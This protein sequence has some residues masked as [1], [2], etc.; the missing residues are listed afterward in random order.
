MLGCAWV[1]AASLVSAAAADDVVLEKPKKQRGVF[2]YAISPDGTRIAGGTGEVTRRADGRNKMSGGEVVLWDARSGKL[3]ET[4]GSHDGTVDWVSFAADGE[5]LASCS[6]EDGVVQWWDVPAGKPKGEIELEG[7]HFGEC[8]PVLSPDGRWVVTVSDVPFQVGVRGRHRGGEVSIWKLDDGQE[9]WSIP[10]S[11]AQ[12]AAIDPSNR[13]LAV[14]MRELQW[15][16][17]AN[18]QWAGRPVREE[19]V[20]YDLASGEARHQR[21]LQAMDLCYTADGKSLAALIWTGVLILS[22]EDLSIQRRLEISGDNW[23]LELAAD[24]GSFGLFH[25]RNRVVEV[26]GMADGALLRR[27][28]SGAGRSLARPALSRDLTR[29]VGDFGADPILRDVPEVTG[30]G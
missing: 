18:G 12:T 28:E 7:A 22:T 11:H 24:G 9:A 23:A 16:Q 5:L 3:S 8:E 25:E 10:E 17:N 14:A 21:K 27:F 30:E 29:V 4:L 6:Y 19:I 13:S 26:R 1:L 2:G 15:R 20:L